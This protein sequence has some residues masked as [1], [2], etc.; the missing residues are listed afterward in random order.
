MDTYTETTG[1]EKALNI[2]AWIAFL[3]SAVVGIVGA[4]YGGVSAGL[5]T[6][7]AAILAATPVTIFISQSRPNAVLERRLHKL[8]AVICGWKGVTAANC[9]AAV[10]LTDSDLI[11]AGSV[12]INGVKFYTDRDTDLTIAYAT[13][14]MNASG[15]CLGNLFTQLL[16]SR[17][18][19]HFDV[20]NFRIYESGGLGGDIGEEPVLAGT[21]S[22]MQAMGVDFPEGTRVNQAVYLAVDG[23]LC[24][25]FALTFGKLKGVSAGLNTLCG[26]RS[27]TP[28]LTCDNF[29]LDEGFIRSK[30]NVNTRRFAFPS[31]DERARL[32]AWNPE[33]SVPCALTTQ[34]GLAPAAFAITGAK[35]L[36]TASIWGAAVH[37]TGGIV[38]IAM[39]LILT[40]VN[41]TELL[42]AS[43]LL[44]FEIIWAIPGLLF[45][46]W[47]RHL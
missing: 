17:N 8:G 26:Y 45:T 25:V 44:L 23:E 32:A 21:L 1:P 24:G 31:L 43:N 28:V 47:S 33:E 13:A 4:V 34:E 9:S 46:E 6:W 35:S 15:S 7:S 37:M 38:G 3:A 30:F 22:F 10:P 20:D 16:E 36:R 41:A 40:L 19:L 18:G 39:V 27:L 11:P 5:H 12:K 2:Y 14:L 42:S 29:L